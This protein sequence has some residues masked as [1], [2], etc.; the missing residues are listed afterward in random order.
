MIQNNLLIR[1]GVFWELP[2][3]FSENHTNHYLYSQTL[4]DFKI[5]QQGGQ[6]CA[7]TSALNSLILLGCISKNLALRDRKHIQTDGDGD[8]EI[9]LASISIDSTSSFSVTVRP[10]FTGLTFMINQL[11]VLVWYKCIYDRN[12]ITF[13]KQ[14]KCIWVFQSSLHGYWWQINR[15]TLKRVTWNELTLMSFA[16]SSIKN[17]NIKSTTQH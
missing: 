15:M 6:T 14:K 7:F 8:T 9:E 12:T 16:Q 3:M 5:S 4:C 10:A 2:D 17:L 1:L 13:G 11:I